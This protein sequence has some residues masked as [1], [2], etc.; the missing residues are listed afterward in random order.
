MLDPEAFVVKGGILALAALT[1]IRFVLY[2]FNNLRIEYRR[3]R[4]RR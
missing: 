1:V 2:E 4:R 3:G